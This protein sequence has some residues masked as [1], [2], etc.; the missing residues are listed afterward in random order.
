MKSY[1][2]VDRYCLV[3]CS[4]KLGNSGDIAECSLA[5]SS[6]ISSGSSLGSGSEGG[7]GREGSISKKLLYKVKSLYL[8]LIRRN[9]RLSLSNFL[10]LL[11]KLLQ[12]YYGISYNNYASWLFELF[13]LS[14][15]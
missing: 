15:E 1:V 2:R 8:E 10:S 13:V 7:F 3:I 5:S 12:T 6:G 11:S 14:G 4:R 9:S